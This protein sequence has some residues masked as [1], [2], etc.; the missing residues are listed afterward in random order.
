MCRAPVK[1]PAASSSS[2]SKRS[3]ARRAGLV[4]ATLP[5]VPVTILG[6]VRV[7]VVD[8]DVSQLTCPAGNGGVLCSTGGCPDAPMFETRGE[9]NLTA[10]NVRRSL[11]V[12]FRQNGVPIL[13]H[14][15]RRFRHFLE[16]PDLYSLTNTDFFPALRGVDLDDADDWSLGK[17]FFSSFRDR[18]SLL[19]ALVRFGEKDPPPPMP[20]FVHSEF[21]GILDRVPSALDATALLYQQ[22]RSTGMR[23]FRASPVCDVEG[24]RDELRRLAQKA[25]ESRSN[26]LDYEAEAVM[27]A[28]N[29]VNTGDSL[30]AVDAIRPVCF[31]S[32]LRP[33]RNCS[34]VTTSEDDTK[35]ERFVR[36]VMMLAEFRRGEVDNCIARHTGESCILPL[37]GTA[38][39]VDPT[40]ASNA[41]DWLHK[42]LEVYPEDQAAKFFKEVAQM[43]LGQASSLEF[44]K[45]H[46]TVSKFPNLAKPLGLDYFGITGANNADDWVGD[47]GLLDVMQGAMVQWPDGPRTL[48]LMKNSYGA[49]GA[50][51]AD[52]SLETNLSQATNVWNIKQTDIDNDGDLDL[53]IARGG[54]ASSFSI[55]NSLLRND[56]GYFTEVTRAAGMLNYQGTHSAEWA[57]FDLDGF[58]DLYVGNEQNPCRL[59]RNRGD[60]TFED[61]TSIAD[62]GKCGVAKGVMWC[63]VNTD[64]W[65]DILVSQFGGANKVF[66]NPRGKKESWAEKAQDMGLTMPRFSFPVGCADL[67]HDG[68]EDVIFAA[69]RTPDPGEVYARLKNE[70]WLEQDIV[71]RRLGE[72]QCFGRQR[73]AKKG[74]RRAARV[75]VVRI[76][77]VR[78]FVRV[79]VLTAESV[80]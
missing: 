73:R 29:A 36:R 59:F 18:V 55:T 60:G 37:V 47:D 58:M 68:L 50:A 4:V 63:D 13:A 41:L 48:T 32:C 30:L 76:F 12:I 67:N 23:Y 35:V 1:E 19:V 3:W 54:W 53:Y 42:E 14:A 79:F 70:P 26:C 31:E 80:G 38:Q 74:G 62:V 15:E 22:Q 17:W 33:Q 78:I 56:G 7:L 11:K 10:E 65:P 43:Q 45:A 8:N 51:F 24:K 16:N 2:S 71:E 49:P 52:I 6:L 9:F 5:L 69:H 46:P 25:V 40:G 57:D 64:G 61:F 44:P 77:V 20:D 75:F 27:T 34:D 21:M 39:H 72:N 66:L 28:I